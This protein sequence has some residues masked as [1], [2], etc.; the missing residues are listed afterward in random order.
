MGQPSPLGIP[1]S[2]VMEWADR[3]GMDE[4]QADDLDILIQAMDREY[5]DWWGA[6]QGKP[7]QQEEAEPD[8]AA[9][10]KSLEARLR[11]LAKAG[12]K[13]QQRK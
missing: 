6:K 1:W 7:Q 2:K 9:A 12:V 3:N 4:L 11:G 5:F 8:P 13:G 10:A